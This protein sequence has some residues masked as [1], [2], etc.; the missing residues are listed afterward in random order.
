MTQKIIV[1]RSRKFNQRTINAILAAEQILGFELRL[2][3]GSYNKGAVSASAGTHDGGGV[4]D[5]G[6]ID[7]KTGLLFPQVRR[8]RIRDAFREVGCPAWIRDPSQSSDFP[9]HIHFLVP[10]DPDMAPSAVRQVAA[11]RAN[12]N[13]LASGAKDDGPR[14][15]VK[16]DFDD[17]LKAHPLPKPKPPATTPD[18]EVFN[19][20]VTLEQL[21]GVLA[22]YMG[23]G[24]IDNDHDEQVLAWQTA[25]QA[26]AIVRFN[27]LAAEK[28]AKNE[29]FTTVK[30]EVFNLLRPLWA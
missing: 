8:E 18:N 15:W 21:D 19:M 4:G 7:K 16:V 5:V 3:Q 22:K 29:A 23:A 24:S 1:W 20:S 26:Y 2:T 11:Y 12:K 13:G 28:V 9:W 14:R 30:A 10:G 6:I 25:A 17:Y 27:E